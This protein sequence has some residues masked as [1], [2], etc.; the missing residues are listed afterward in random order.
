MS[1]TH[2]QRTSEHFVFDMRKGKGAIS[3]YY[4]TLRSARNN[5]V[6]FALLFD[7]LPSFFQQAFKEALT[8]NSK[9]LY[10]YIF[11]A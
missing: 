11:I 4:T 7:V 6:L 1:S 3:W 2:L 5:F 10:Y 9:T 8:S